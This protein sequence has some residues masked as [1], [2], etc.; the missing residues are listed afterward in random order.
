VGGTRSEMLFG[1]G[2]RSG[3]GRFGK[4][5][6]AG[7]GTGFVG[8]GG[9]V[10]HFESGSGDVAEFVSKIPVVPPVVLEDPLEV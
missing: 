5:V 3:F 2:W 4:E 6:E 1:F 9:F 10:V 8:F 7:L